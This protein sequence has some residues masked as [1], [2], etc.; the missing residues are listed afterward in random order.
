M[1]TVSEGITLDDLREFRR[2]FRPPMQPKTRGFWIYQFSATLEDGEEENFDFRLMQFDNKKEAELI[3]GISIEDQ[4][5]DEDDEWSLNQCEGYPR[6]PEMTFESVLEAEKKIVEFLN[7][8]AD[9]AMT[10][11]EFK[12]KLDIAIEQEAGKQ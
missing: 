9:E 10:E 6:L 2:E 12:K 8:E 5:I 3:Q 11:E 4:D 7:G 1:I